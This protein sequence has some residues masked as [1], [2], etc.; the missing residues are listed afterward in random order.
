MLIYVYTTYNSFLNTF[1]RRET[2]AVQ[3]VQSA[4]D[5]KN[6]VKG[7]Q[8]WGERTTKMGH[9]TTK[10]GRNPQNISAGFKPLNLSFSCPEI[11]PEICR[12]YV[13]HTMSIGADAGFGQNRTL[14]ISQILTSADSIKW[15]YCLLKYPII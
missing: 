2:V 8:K 4:K 9:T 7:R 3:H 5:D 1:T 13:Y 12:I 6:G 10:M 11:G 15:L 14:R